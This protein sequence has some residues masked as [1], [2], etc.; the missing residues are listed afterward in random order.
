MANKLLVRMAEKLFTK[1]FPT[2]SVVINLARFSK[3]KVY[4]PFGSPCS[5]IKARSFKLSRAVI[6]VS[7]P[8][9]KAERTS[10][11]ARTRIS[12]PTFPSKGIASARAN[13][14]S[15]GKVVNTTE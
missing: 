7:E 2:N 8:E 12:S 14:N 9:K 10:M 5:L 4:I 6:A 13:K 11:N 1:L 15:D 3:T